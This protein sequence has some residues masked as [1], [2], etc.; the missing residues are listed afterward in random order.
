VAVLLAYHVRLNGHA[1]DNDW[2]DAVLEELGQEIG[3][4]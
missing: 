2:L 1:P 4:E 3:A